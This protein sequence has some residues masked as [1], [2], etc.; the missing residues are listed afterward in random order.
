MDEG[1]SWN[2]NLSISYVDA[3]GDPSM[4][5]TIQQEETKK[6]EEQR[7]LHVRTK[8]RKD[9][10]YTINMPRLISQ[11]INITAVSSIQAHSHL[12]ISHLQSVKLFDQDI[13]LS[14]FPKC[15]SRP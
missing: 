6:I 8:R 1:M 3:K 4:L 5:L 2:P 14:L 9:S 12:T 15:S 7:A 11:N 10:I 13:N